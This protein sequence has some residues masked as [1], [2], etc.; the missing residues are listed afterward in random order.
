MSVIAS[1]RFYLYGWIYDALI[2]SFLKGVR[3]KIANYIISSNLYPVLDV[4]CGTG[5]QCAS[6]NISE[7]MVMGFDCDFKMMIYASF[8]YSNIPFICADASDMPFKPQSIKSIIISFSIH[9]KPCELRQKMLAEAMKLLSP[10]GKIILVDFV[11]PWNF[12]SRLGYSLIYVVEK[13]AGKEH[14]RN[15]RKFLQGGGLEGFLKYYDFKKIISYNLEL[16]CSRLVIV[17]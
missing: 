7:D 4:C 2:N 11:H 5:K 17:E 16:L 6:L 14:F 13:L 1:P 10:N 12:V 3:K 15:G 9:D 8:K